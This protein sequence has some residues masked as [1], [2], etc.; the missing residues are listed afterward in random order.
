[1]TVIT[2][3]ELRMVDLAPK[4][5]RTD[6]IQSFVS[7]ETP[8]VTIYDSDGASGTGYSYT[9]GTGGP[10]V[11]ALLEHTL[12]PQLIGRDPSRI[13]HIWRDLMF[14]THATA[15]GAITSLA[16]A[17]IDTALWDLHCKKTGLPLWKAAGGNRNRIPLY[18]TEG[19]WLHLE[20][21]ALVEDA[22]AM[23]EQGFRGS[24]IKIGSQHLSQDAARLSAVRAAVGDGYEILTDANQ[25]FTL[26]EAIRRARVLEDH[27][28]GWFEEPL[29]ADDV[30]GHVELARRTSVP[31][32]VGESMYSL[33]QFKDYLQMGAASIVQVD[34][35]RIGGITP[36]LKVAHLAEAFNVMVCPHFLMELHLPLVCAI[37]NAKWLE[38]IPQLDSITASAMQIED[39]HGIPSDTPGL[40]IHW[41]WTAIDQLTPTQTIKAG[42]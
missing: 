32:A 21:S 22:L 7:Q 34:V 42:A 15:V 37:P 12:A 4:V 39:G 5:K 17:A 29:P 40:G 8:I 25:G 38:Y 24:K 35:A 10:S 28:I 23:Q 9:I 2:H 36:W 11:M 20:Q 41:D 13:D 6:A 26:S 14:S 1:M 33:S 31:I 3:I 19:G 27:G 18:S 30:A 16:L